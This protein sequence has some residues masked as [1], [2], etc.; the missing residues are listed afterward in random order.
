MGAD[1]SSETVGAAP[2]PPP[3]PCRERFWGWGCPP[4]PANSVGAPELH[5]PLKEL[6]TGFLK[7]AADGLFIRSRHAHRSVASLGPANC[8][9]PD[10]RG[11]RQ[12]LGTPSNESSCRP[13]LRA[14][15]MCHIV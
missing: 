6:D 13:K 8:C 15:D 3:K 14:G 7:G 2:T 10:L 9:D 5:A 11:R 4:F 12:I 1:K